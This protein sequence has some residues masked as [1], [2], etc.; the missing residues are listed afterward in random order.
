ML[1]DQ[2]QEIFFFRPT[3]YNNARAEGLKTNPIFR[4][5]YMQAQIGSN[6]LENADL[7]GKRLLKI[8]F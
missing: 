2:K 8:K 6:T 5:T 3:H 4:K 1:Q 7:V